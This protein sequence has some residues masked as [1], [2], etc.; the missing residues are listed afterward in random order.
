MVLQIDSLLARLMLHELY[1]WLLSFEKL[2]DRLKDVRSLEGT[3]L[4]NE[5]TLN[6]PLRVPSR[7]IFRGEGEAE[8]V[9]VVS[10]RLPAPVSSDGGGITATREKVSIANWR[11]NMMDAAL[12]A[13][14]SIESFL[15]RPLKVDVELEGDMGAQAVRWTADRL[16]VPTELRTDRARRMENVSLIWDEGTGTHVSGK[17]FLED[18]AKIDIDLLSEK[19]GLVHQTSSHCG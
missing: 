1:P 17:L 3:L 14:G 18:G 10:P 4:I 5:L 15:E 13:S 12:M 6:G 7:W 2:K 11:I 19:E 16:K 9:K 8:T